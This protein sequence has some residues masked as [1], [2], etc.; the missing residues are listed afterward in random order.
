MNNAH[1]LLFFI[2]NLFDLAPLLINVCFA[3]VRK[4]TGG[5]QHIITI[6]LLFSNWRISTIKILS[7]FLMCGIEHTIDLFSMLTWWLT[8]CLSQLP[9]CQGRN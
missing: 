7:H 8:I 6:V 5:L 1:N 3:V 4:E 9:L 2:H